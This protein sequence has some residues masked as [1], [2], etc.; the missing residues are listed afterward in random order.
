MKDPEPGHAGE[1]P[2]DARR[3]GAGSADRIAARPRALSSSTTAGKTVS[4]KWFMI[5]G[6]D[7]TGEQTGTV[8]SIEFTDR[9]PAMDAPSA[10]SSSRS[11]TTKA[12]LLPD[13]KVLIGQGVN[14]SAELR[15]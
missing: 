8:E 12:V 10:T 2:L 13:G 1:E 6:Q 9:D 7:A 3:H 4:H 14:R 15:R 11:S 5:S